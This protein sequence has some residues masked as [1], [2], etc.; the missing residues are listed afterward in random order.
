MLNIKNNSRTKSKQKLK[1]QY[2]FGRECKFIKDRIYKLSV[3]ILLIACFFL[4][5]ILFGSNQQ[6]V[7]ANS[8]ANQLTHGFDPEV[9]INNVLVISTEFDKTL[10]SQQASSPIPLPAANHLMLSLLVLEQLELDERIMPSINAIKFGQEDQKN[11]SV[12]I[13]YNETYLVSNL[14][15]LHMYEHSSAAAMVLAEHLAGSEEACVELMNEKAAQLEM[16]DTNFTNILGFADLKEGK[17]WS[18]NFDLIEDADL[19]NQKSTLVDLAK[20]VTTLTKNQTANQMFSEREYFTRMPDGT[21]MALMHPFDQIFASIDQ[22]V[23]GAWNFKQQDMS[24]SMVTGEKNQIKYLVFMSD[25]T[26]NNFA[27]QIIELIQNIS[28]HYVVTPLVTQG[29]AYPSY[30]QTKE[31]D[32]IG[33]LFLKTVNYIHPVHDSF[34]HP[35]VKYISHGPH[36]RPL[37]RGT[38]VGHVIFTLNDG[39]QIEAEVGSDISILS[40]NTLL[41]TM[42]NSL[43]RNPNLNKL[44]IALVVLLCIILLFKIFRLAKALSRQIH[45][46]KLN[47]IQKQLKD[48]IDKPQ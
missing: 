14:L 4:V 47:N 5:L 25:K 15:A 12:T 40:G 24:F 8:D 44:I 38:P 23:S 7:Y 11:H 42:I 37:A 9:S 28:E 16:N 30:D 43:Q 45:L 2:K 13:E 18:S 46:Y 48:R 41:S 29:Q 26:K 20:L 32:K 19:L 34:L 1:S 33:L 21:I 17:K 31:G 39:S 36:S 6:T 10:F 35:A 22:G 27:K 3:C